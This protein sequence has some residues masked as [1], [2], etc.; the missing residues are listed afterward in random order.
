MPQ[1]RRPLPQGVGQDFSPTCSGCVAKT[2]RGTQGQGGSLFLL[3]LGGHSKEAGN[4]GDLPVGVSFAHCADLS[5]PDHVHDLVSLERSPCCL[6]G[7][8]AHPGLDQPFEKAVVLL[9]DG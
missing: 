2:R 9:V 4:E 8:E 5:L 6:E 3:G 7:K 1:L